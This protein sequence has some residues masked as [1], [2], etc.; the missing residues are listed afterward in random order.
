MGDCS[1]KENVG[2]RKAKGT[3]PSMREILM[4]AI[5]VADPRLE[6]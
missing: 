3:Y 2:G 1:P 5:L 6:S 4:M